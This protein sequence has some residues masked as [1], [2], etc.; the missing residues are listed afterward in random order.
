MISAVLVNFNEA[1]SLK[2]C[3]K[4]LAGFADEIVVLDIGSS[5]QSIAVCKKY[6]VTVFKHS[7][8]PYVEKVRNDAW[9]KANGDWILV[10][11]P[12]EVIG[13]TL[14]EKL[15]EIVLENRYQ[16]VN[17]PRKNIF[18]NH[19]IAHTNWWPDYHVRF[20][21]KGYVKWGDK[22]HE[23]PA[24]RGQMLNLEA[25]ED[26]AISHFGYD[27]VDEFM[28]RQNRYSSIEAGNLFAS[29]LKFSWFNFFWKPSRE[30]L[31]RFIRHGGFLDGIY[32]FTLSFL[33]MIYELQV[34]IKLWEL[35]KQKK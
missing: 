20:F 1:D 24:V 2:R 13:D 19:W 34:L 33:M 31:V 3:F 21:K 30:F 17:I 11:D 4:S 9:L 23:Y 5:D 22:I 7:F 35:E 18:F 29:G 25:K 8:V 28:E 16:A 27:S 26:L 14:K 15:K 12:D 6:G 10:L 32:G